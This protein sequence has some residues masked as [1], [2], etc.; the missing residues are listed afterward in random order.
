MIGIAEALISGT[1]GHYYSDHKYQLDIVLP[2]D[3]A[4]PG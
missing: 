2:V 1:N 4:Y 3:T